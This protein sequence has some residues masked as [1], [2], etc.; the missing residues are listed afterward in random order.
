M[1]KKPAKTL[2][3]IKGVRLRTQGPQQSVILRALGI[4]PISIPGG[5]MYDA[6]QRGMVDGVVGP[7]TLAHDFK[8]YELC[9]HYT[10][11]DMYVVSMGLVINEKVWNGLPE[12]V[13]KIMQDL[14][15]ARMAEACGASYDK[16][17]I[18][19]ADTAK[20]AG[21]QFYTLSK[22]EKEKWIALTKPL[23]DKWIADMEA[24]GLPG[25]QVYQDMIQILP[26]Y[27]K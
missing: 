4:S 21:G 5:D 17:D 12:E 18:I 22:D 15:G 1:T 16:Y 10:I 24:K 14:A 11:I 27:S 8:L 13:K 3:D 25:K 7:L 9:K 19:G 20:K 2:A 23:N 26:K 6:V